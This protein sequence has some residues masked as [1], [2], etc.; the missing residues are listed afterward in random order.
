MKLK[1]YFDSKELRMNLSDF[2]Q[3]SS[4]YERVKRPDWIVP[5]TI[6]VILIVIMSYLL[7]AIIYYG[8]K[9]GKWKRYD[10]NSVDNNLNA[11]MVYTC[12]VYCDIMCLMRCI[13]SQIHMNVGFKEGDSTLCEPVADAAFIAYALVLWSVFMLL[14][15]RQKA[16][17][18][19]RMLSIG[20]TRSVRFLSF[21]SIVLIT[22]AGLGYVLFFT[23]PTNYHFSPMGCIYVAGG[24]LRVSYGIYAIAVV[25]VAQTM[26]LCLFIYPLWEIR[27]KPL[28]KIKK[29]HFRK[30]ENRTT[31]RKSS[32]FSLPFTETTS[33]Q[34]KT[35]SRTDESAEISIQPQ[36][37]TSLKSS[38]PPSNGI[39]KILTKTLLFAILSTMF[40]VFLQV[41]T[42]YVIVVTGHRRFNII[43]FDIAAFVNLLFLIFS[44]VTAK[45][46]MFPFCYRKYPNY[47]IR[48]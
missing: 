11:G 3:S 36:R 15:F 18:T 45:K 1:A 44:F 40:D 47:I 5:V 39:K 26:L 4:F 30:K 34:S 38:R 8:L 16:F 48:S 27:S 23:I 43:L 2:N 46:I 13:I 22:I 20:A 10:L 24:A 6:N 29:N 31:D 7:V 37:N 32:N 14:W 28:T 19:N 25:F 42:K 17:Y 35:D 12:L 33:T 21:G 9:T 41:F